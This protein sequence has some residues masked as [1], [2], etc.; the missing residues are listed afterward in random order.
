[1]DFDGTKNGARG[2]CESRI[3]F[4]RSECLSRA[5]EVCSESLEVVVLFCKPDQS[6]I[7]YCTKMI[8]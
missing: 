1:M 4:P 2:D 5:V 7:T 3:S 8:P 6:G